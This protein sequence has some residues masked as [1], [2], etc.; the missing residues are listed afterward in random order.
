MPPHTTLGVELSSVTACWR[1][2]P[3]LSG[4][5]R[6]ES[7]RHPR[8]SPL[9][10]MTPQFCWMIGRGAAVSRTRPNPRASAHLTLALEHCRARAGLFS[11]SPRGSVQRQSQDKT[12]IQNTGLTDDPSRRLGDQGTVALGHCELFPQS[13]RAHQAIEANGRA[14][15]HSA[16]GPRQA[17]P[18]WLG[19]GGAPCIGG[20][21]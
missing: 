15:C 17:S 8:D 19:R 20:T 12:P 18:S 10:D 9:H 11:H 21:S 1:S 7:C 4:A 2:N 16:G 3:P 14:K 5:A 6:V 13:T